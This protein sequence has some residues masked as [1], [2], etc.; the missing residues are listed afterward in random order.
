[1]KDYSE[2]LRTLGFRFGLYTNYSDYAPVN[3]NWDEDKV[4][5]LPNSDWQRAWPRNYALK[6]SYAREFEESYAPRIH[7][8]FGTSA[9]Y[10]DVHTALIPWD[11]TDYDARVPGAGMFRSVF[12]SF[13]ELLFKETKFHD[14][15]VFSEG[16]MHWLYAG[17][18]D[19]NYAQIV[20]RAPWKEPLLVDFDLLKIHPLQT[21]FGMGMPSMFYEG[22]SEWMN[23]RDFHSPFFDRF[24]AATIAYGH[25]GYLTDEWG[26]AG[27]LKS[28]FLLQQLQRRYATDTVAEIKYERDGKLLSTSEALASDCAQGRPAFREI[29]RRIDIVRELQREQRLANSGRWP[30]ARSA[31]IWFLRDGR[32]RIRGILEDGWESTSGVCQLPGIP[33]RGYARRVCEVA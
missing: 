11:R 16:R 4:S 31:A 23:D 14:G 3:E 29:C 1:M 6:P 22:S 27:T 21:D 10:C 25:I 9:G 17:L 12:E 20:S 8:E 28:Y 7:E 19:G 33:L 15:P 32:E 13:G 24:V 18:A 5:R 26:F 2:L 30:V